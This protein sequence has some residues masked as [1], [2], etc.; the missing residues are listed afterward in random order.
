M[1]VSQSVGRSGRGRQGGAMIG[2]VV[3][4]WWGGVIARRE[5]RGRRLEVRDRLTYVHARHPGKGY[6]VC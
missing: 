3:L 2:G 4:V 6:M 1:D 5:Q